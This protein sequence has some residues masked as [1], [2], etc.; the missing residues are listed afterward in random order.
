MSIASGDAWFRALTRAAGATFLGLMLLLMS[1]LTITALPAVARFGWRFPFT[2]TW[3]PVAEQFGGLPFIYGTAVSSLLA[4]LLAVPLAIGAA[5]YL[6]ELAPAGLRAPIGFLIELLAAIPS[7]V[8]GL[9]GIFVLAPW[10]S[11]QL[12]PAL[13]TWLGFLPLFQGPP[14]GIGMLAAGIVLAIMIVPI[15]TAV[16]HDV[17]RAVPDH[18]R[19][20]AIALGATRWETTRLAVLRY[21]RSGL[22]GAVLLGLGRALGETMAVTML[23]GNRHEIAA[24][25]FAPGYTM[26]AAIANEFSEAVGDMHLSA[27]AYVAFLL[28]VVTVLV[29]AGARLLIWRVARGS[30]VGSRAL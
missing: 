7:V 21:G 22:I 16:A 3:D 28:F 9:W 29:N 15:I 11:H 20:A 19:E 27:L 26:A 2:S 25:L 10:L 23:I 4:L 17:L 6:V 8:Y 14:Y 24:S 1:V 5:I 12:E 18:Q 30:G 13:G